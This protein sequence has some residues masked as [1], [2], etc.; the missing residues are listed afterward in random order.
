MELLIK[1]SSYIIALVAATVTTLMLRWACK[2][3]SVVWQQRVKDS[4]VYLL[5]IPLAL[6]AFT[7]ITHLYWEVVYFTWNLW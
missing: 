5:G 3:I 2:R 4:S 7:I 1:Y 6:A